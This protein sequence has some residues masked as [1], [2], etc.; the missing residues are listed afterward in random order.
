MAV[1]IWDDEAII[2]AMIKYRQTAG[3]WPKSR[4]WWF[5]NKPKW[6]SF[7]TVCNRPLKWTGLLK[8][9]K[10]RVRNASTIF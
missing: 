9:A 1:E 10:E 7:T 3:R 6:P 5:A 4:D 8:L 2:V